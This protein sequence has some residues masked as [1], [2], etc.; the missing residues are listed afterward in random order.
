M[1]LSIAIIGFSG[2]MGKK[3][4][5]LI[6][7]DDTLS[8][9]NTKNHS[10]EELDYL[11]QAADV[12]I[13]FSHP[14]MLPYLLQVASSTQTP[15]VSGTTGL[16]LEDKEMMQK[17]SEKIPILYSSNFSIGIALCHLLIEKIAPSFGQIADIDIVETHHRHK[18]D[19]PSGT[20]I[21][22]KETL[23]RHLPEKEISLHSIRAGSIVGEHN[24][25]FNTDEEQI[26]LSHKALTRH[27]FAKG[28]LLAAK[29]IH[30]KEKGMYS[31]FD[32]F[33]KK[34]EVKI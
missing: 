25:I 1:T 30:G 16:S 4:F 20:A 3:V 2:K 19:A 29:F 10:Q 21:S 24:L 28:A 15:I 34:E 32:I 27:C 23:K 26:T 22:L 7:N 12:L 31:I 6:Q 5:E 33:A 9:I 18:K 13:D 8:C 17:A 11:A 14:K